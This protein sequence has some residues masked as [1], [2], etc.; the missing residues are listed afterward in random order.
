MCHAVELELLVGSSELVCPGTLVASQ[1]INCGSNVGSGYALATLNF[2]L[3]ELDTLTLTSRPCDLLFS[4]PEM[5]RI[6][7][8]IL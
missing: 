3:F 8:L 5:L 2:Q 6:T 7:I 4:L 1:F